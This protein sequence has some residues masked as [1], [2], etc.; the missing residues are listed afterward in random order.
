MLAI[1][2]MTAALLCGIR[3]PGVLLA[4]CL[5]TYQASS[6]AQISWLGE[7]YIAAAAVIAMLRFTKAGGRTQFH[8]LDGALALLVL[9]A[10]LSTAYAPNP[11]EAFSYFL[12]LLLSAGGMYAV[13]RVTVR[14]NPDRTMTELLVGLAAIGGFL[15]LLLASAESVGNITR[16]ILEDATAVGL[17]QPFPY[18]AVAAALLLLQTRRLWAQALGAGAMAAVLYTAILSGTRSAFLAAIVAMIVALPMIW[19]RAPLRTTGVLGV[20][21]VLAVVSAPLFFSEQLAPALERLT[22][23]FTGGGIDLSDASS[24]ERWY[25]FYSAWDMFLESPII[26]HGHG[27]FSQLTVYPYPHNLFLEAGSE[28]GLIGLVL[29]AA[30]FALLGKAVLRVGEVN[31]AAGLILAAMASVAFVQMMVSFSLFMARPPFLV[32]ALAAAMVPP[33]MRQRK[34]GAR[35]RAA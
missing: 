14:D 33:V 18:V 13:A 12:R 29:A 34:R 19:R 21:I 16:L 5:F 9:W 28:L 6:L 30:W 1:L 27:S 17:A 10:G 3:W 4:G 26:G 23:N 2:A 32:A 7:V 8:A 20:A 31:P 22:M 25:A 11:N 35:L 24:R 15:A